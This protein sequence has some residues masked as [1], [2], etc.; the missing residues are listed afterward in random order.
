MADDPTQHPVCDGCGERHEQVDPV[1]AVE[2]AKSA[3]VIEAH[4]IAAEMPGKFPALEHALAIGGAA[5]REVQIRKF[6]ET[7]AEAPTAEE[8]ER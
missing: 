4:R 2:I 6:A 8:P 1:V 3:V 7:L 5:W